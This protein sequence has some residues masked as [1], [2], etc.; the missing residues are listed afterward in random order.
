MGL[1][2]PL[3][4]LLSAFCRARRIAVTAAAL[5]TAASAA[6]AD[7]R[8]FD[9]PAQ[10]LSTALAALASQADISIGLTGV[11]L[12]NRTSRDLVG[13]DDVGEALRRLL[14]GTGLDFEMID[15]STWRI[16]ETP[17]AAVIAVQEPTIPVAPPLV[18]QVT[19]TATKRPLAIQVAPLSVA[20]VTGTSI[21]DYGLHTTSEASSLVAGLSATNQSPG[22]S[23]FIIRGLSDG[24]FIGNTQSTVSIY[25]DE[26]RANFNGPD[27]N[28]QLFDIDRVE[29]LRGPQGTIYGAG[30][31]GGLVRIITRKPVL[32]KYEEHASV[33]GSVGG[34][35][36]PSGIAEATVNLPLIDD[37]LAM[38]AVAYV[39][40][41]GGYVDNSH[42]GTIGVNT[43]DISG[44][45]SALRYS[46]SPDWSLRTGVTFQ[47]MRSGDTQYYDAAMRRFSRGNL[48]AEPS[49][50]DFLNVSAGL[51][52]DL[53]WADLTSTTAWLYN[54][55][56][57]RYDAS[58][59]LPTLIHIPVEPTAF[60]Q[61]S[62]YNTINH[63]TRLVSIPGGDFQWLAGIF[64]SKRHDATFSTLTR[65]SQSPGIF[66]SK[67]RYDNGI[68]TALFGEA[69]Y[70]LNEYLSASAGLRFYRGA[71]NTS[72][73]NSELI[74]VGPSEAFGKN[75]TFGT[76]PRAEITFQPDP[77][78]LFY[79]EVAQGFR[80]GGINI[81]SRIVA[82]A[83]GSGRPVTASNFQSDQLWNFELGSKSSFFDRA[84]TLNATAFYALWSNMQADLIRPSGLPVTANVGDVRNYGFEAEGTFVP[85]EHFHFLANLSWANPVLTNTNPALTTLSVS[86]L[87]VTP[88]FSVT[89]AAQYQTPLA[90]DYLGFANV[91]Y[92]LFGKSRLTNDSGA[93]S[94]VHT[95]HVVNLRLGVQHKQWKLTTYVNNLTGDT[96]NTYAFGNPF[97]LGHISQETPPRPR[98]IGLNLAWSN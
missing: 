62:R 88:K 77:D 52:G 75:K 17:V 70:K 94:S 27:P 95:Y 69:T 53:H 65:L 4:L 23:K 47:A 87:P 35:V 43:T 92:E 26:T 21:A 1:S 24:P 85:N 72:A 15:P 34:A 10:S 42:L 19:V 80:L 8:P 5:L 40:H 44:V 41:M 78:N 71:L 50:N 2:F 11:N 66:Y 57:A 25:L 33:E 79:A 46:L 97:S 73:N 49:K 68:E 29:V 18:E 96:S 61:A 13:Y 76:R 16:F 28:L 60:N 58:Q 82:P 36:D 38:R 64:F 7:P 9:I 3:D 37:V 91:K 22:Q 39:R 98:T 59:S 63:E 84:L 20:A 31:I 90:T 56:S 32:G 48:L 93:M 55:V 54:R 14:R 12:T 81:A 83:V 6:A 45:R 74:D 86:R 67:N 51:D 89:M 30:S